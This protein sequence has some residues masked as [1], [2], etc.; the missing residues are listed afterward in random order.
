ME[1]YSVDSAK[2][3]G[4]YRG[5]NQFNDI[6]VTLIIDRLAGRTFSERTSETEGLGNS[7]MVVLLKIAKSPNTH[8]KRRVA[9]L[10]SPWETFAMAF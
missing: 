5:N 9:I 10:N 6:L 4:T 8:L 2:P 1:G 3:V 7:P